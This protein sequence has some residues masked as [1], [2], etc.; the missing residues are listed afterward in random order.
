ML[1]LKRLLIVCVFFIAFALIG[2]PAYALKYTLVAPT[3]TLTRGQEVTFTIN[4]NTEGAKVTTGQIGLTYDT[5]Y[6]QYQRIA[7]GQA[8]DSVSADTSATGKLTL[9]GNSSNGFTGTNNFALVYFKLIAQ[10]SGTTDLCTLEAVTP[11]PTTAPTTPPSQPTNSPPVAPTALP[12]TGFADTSN[13]VG[14]IGG[15]LVLMAVIIY[16]IQKLI[17]HSHSKNKTSE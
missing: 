15:L 1:L 9:T 12:K 2:K 16:L 10:A 6:L 8:M 3:G 5:Q 14:L 4:I 11:T 17:P 13:Q 7:P